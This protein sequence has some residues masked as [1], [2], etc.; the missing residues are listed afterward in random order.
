MT[1]QATPRDDTATS[2]P[3]LAALMGLTRLPA[4]TAERYIGAQF[5]AVDRMLAMR[6]VLGIMSVAFVLLTSW[7]LASPGLLA[8]WALAALTSIALPFQAYRRRCAQDYEALSRKDLWRHAGGLAAQGLIW[9]GPMMVLVSPGGLIEVASLWT[10]TSC[11]IAAV[12]M[13]FYPTPL[14]ALFF[15]LV[16]SG[17]SM[18]MMYRAG[19]GGL[20]LTVASFG[21]LMLLAALRQGRM[22]GRD[23]A[24]SAQLAE[25]QETVRMLLGEHDESRT[26]WLWQTD[27]ARRLT[28]VTP[29]FARMTGIAVADIEGKSVLEIL[30]GSAWQGGDFHPALHTLAARLKAREPFTDLVLPVEVEGVRRW[31]RLSAS[32]RQDDRGAFTGFRGVGSDV[33]AERETAERITQLAM[34]D[35]L[36]QLP[37]RL[38]LTE[39][40]GRVVEAMGKW[41]IRSAFLMIDLD[42]F[43]AINDTLGH[44]IGDL[45]LA[46][47][48]ER[49]RGVCA[50][51][52]IAG[53]LGGDEFAV[54]VPELLPD[55]GGASHVERLSDAIIARL[56]QPY[57]VEQ[58]VLFVGASIGSATGPRDG[59]TVDTL[60]RSADLAMY[61]A[62]EEGGG[63]HFAYVATL[64][65][66]VEVRR[67]MEMALRGAIENGELRLEY[68]PVVDCQTG[69]LYSFESLV[70]WHHPEFGEVP[71]AKFIRLAEEARLMVPLG[72]WILE[73]ACAEATRWPAMVGL[74][75]NLSPEQLSDPGIIAT[76]KAVLAS[77]GLEPERLE[78]EVTESIFLREGS[79]A[80]K[81]LEQIGALGIGLALDDFGTGYSSFG[82]LSSTR[83]RTIKIDRSFVAG[84]SAGRVESVAIINAVVALATSLGIATVAEGVETEQE[85]EMVRRSGCLRIQGYYIGRA[86]RTEDVR[87]LFVRAA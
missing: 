20:A 33:T 70:R 52:A 31:W 41:T 64:H 71:P 50:E 73:T 18:Q 22:F 56:S 84:A 30:A 36:T 49:L 54:I 76:L 43:K 62:K 19:N 47:V 87:R 60:V 57:E 10:M 67:K 16:V 32:P 7:H 77:T 42:R 17:G 45:L 58:H 86:M 1:Q 2:A 75:V 27:T 51:G 82:Y 79:D 35:P 9:V 69:E 68:Q 4:A 6:V 5:R 34:Y 39:E 55:Q 85:L 29:H 24:T 23:I 40:L 3:S 11:L 37:N 8:L 38:H 46:Q 80:V 81:R 28:G 74:S 26:D 15:L 25:K 44:H 12:A 63:R 83:F 14:S 48:A 59:R 72:A 61:R 66:D 78:L 65:A 13:G 53:R 21:L